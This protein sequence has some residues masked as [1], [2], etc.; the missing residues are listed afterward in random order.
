MISL[1]VR[2]LTGQEFRLGVERSTLG[3]EV[4]KIEVDK[5]SV[6]SGAK[7][8]LDHTRHQTLQ[9][10]GLAEAKTAMLC[11]TFVPTLCF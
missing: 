9:E 10:Q 4:R 3:S 8:V 2:S 1:D 6:R 5:L 11:C 7:L